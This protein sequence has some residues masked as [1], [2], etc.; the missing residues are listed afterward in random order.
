MAANDHPRAKGDE[1]NAS[2]E[3]S[4]GAESQARALAH[5]W[6]ARSNSGDDCEN[7]DDRED[8][9]LLCQLGL[10]SEQHAK[11]AAECSATVSSLAGLI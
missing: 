6:E 7:G 4:E 9:Q 5:Y 8:N 2:A 3:A 11:L 1:A 10:D